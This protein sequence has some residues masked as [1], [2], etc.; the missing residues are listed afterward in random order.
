MALEAGGCRAWTPSPAGPAC[1]LAASRG[2]P[3]PGL[4][5]ASPW[6]VLA[7][8]RQQ[9]KRVKVVGGGHS[10]SDIACT[11]GFMIHMGKMNRVLQV[12]DPLA[13]PP[14]QPP[15]RQPRSPPQTPGGNSQPSP[16]GLMPSLPQ[17]QSDTPSPGPPVIPLPRA[18]PGLAQAA[19]LVCAPPCGH[20]RDVLP[21]TPR[22]QSFLSTSVEQERQV[23]SP[24]MDSQ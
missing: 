19:C 5:Q 7:L 18:L 16:S 20:R 6:Q 4:T 22:R 1:R 17:S 14:L 2:R 11:D 24:K 10:P 3:E 9:N 15:R 13:S 21:P 23:R 8:A 12:R